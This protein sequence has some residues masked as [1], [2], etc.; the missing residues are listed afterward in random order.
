[1]RLL[2]LAPVIG[3]PRCFCDR[4]T[5]VSASRGCAVDVPDYSHGNAAPDDFFLGPLRADSC[6]APLC[7]KVIV[8]WGL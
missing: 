8:N 4:W 7:F 5:L 2:R 3:G 1:M 6:G